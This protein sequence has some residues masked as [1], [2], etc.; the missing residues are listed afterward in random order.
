LPN[1][2]WR[3]TEDPRILQ[4]SKEGIDQI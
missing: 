2:S 3:I 4:L 1:F